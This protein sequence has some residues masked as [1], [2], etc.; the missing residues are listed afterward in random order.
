MTRIATALTLT[1]LGAAA[2]AG[3][4]HTKNA[5]DT[6]EAQLRRVIDQARLALNRLAAAS[7]RGQVKPIATASSKRPTTKRPREVRS[8]A[9]DRVHRLFADL[10]LD[11][12]HIIRF[13]VR[14]RRAGSRFY[15]GAKI[16]DGVK[17]PTLIGNPADPITAVSWERL[18][19][20]TDGRLV[21]TTMIQPED[22]PVGVSGQ[23]VVTLD[24]ARR[25]FPRTDIRRGV[26][27]AF[28]D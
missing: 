23:R 20:S 5:P 8:P 13:R 24:E 27:A 2:S 11:P 22:H 17:S 9:L 16:H 12:R 10:G 4:S 28:T 19:V 14:D 21:I 26:R 15:V 1:L 3:T 7:A 18:E 25:A 6:W